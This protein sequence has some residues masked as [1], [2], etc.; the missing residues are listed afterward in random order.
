MELNTIA[1]E[2]K[3]KTAKELVEEL[4]VE[5]EKLREED[6]KVKNLELVVTTRLDLKVGKCLCKE[7]CTKVG[8]TSR[9]NDVA[10]VRLRG[11]RV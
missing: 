8:F 2:V 4:V 6:I 10:R 1:P 11:A 5:Q 3:K 9:K 7:D